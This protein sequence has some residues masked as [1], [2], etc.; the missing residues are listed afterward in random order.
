[1]LH[2]RHPNLC[3]PA[4][5]ERVPLAGHCKSQ[6][7]SDV[8]RRPELSRLTQ[9]RNSC[10]GLSIFPPSYPAR[11]LVQ[12]S[13]ERSLSY[14]QE[15]E[16]LH[17]LTKIV[18]DA[19]LPF[20]LADQNFTGPSPEHGQVEIQLAQLCLRDDPTQSQHSSS[21]VEGLRIVIA[22]VLGIV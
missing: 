5:S 12:R 10:R 8:F 2:T 11:L 22:P 3:I 1:M 16:P 4:S 7:L 15:A 21:S 17:K 20:Q 14:L 18:P 6:K 19:L 9:V 13:L